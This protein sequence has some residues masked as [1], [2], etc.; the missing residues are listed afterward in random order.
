MADHSQL[1]HCATLPTINVPCLSLCGGDSGCFPVEALCAVARLVP[2]CREDVWD[3]CNHWLYIKEPRRFAATL[4]TFA[5]S[6]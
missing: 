6:L 1:N 3:G 4:L 5:R 2:M